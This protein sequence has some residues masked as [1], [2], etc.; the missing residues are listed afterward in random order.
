MG[1][2]IGKKGMFTAFLAGL[3]L[4]ISFRFLLC[5]LIIAFGGFQ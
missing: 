3:L 2:L 4:T 5:G 1:N